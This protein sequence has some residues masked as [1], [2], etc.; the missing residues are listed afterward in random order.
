MHPFNAELRRRE[1]CGRP[2]EIGSDVGRGAL[3]VSSVRIGSTG[4]YRASVI[5]RDIPES[6][7]ASGNQWRRES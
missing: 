4:R 1:E 6:V 7:F 2:V 3:M 5:A